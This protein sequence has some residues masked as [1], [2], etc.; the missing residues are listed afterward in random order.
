VFMLGSQQRKKQLGRTLIGLL[1]CLFLVNNSFTPICFLQ[2]HESLIGLTI[3]IVIGQI[4]LIAVWAAL[5]QKNLLFRLLWSVLL[6]IMIWLSLI[7]GWRL[8]TSLVDHEHSWIVLVLRADTTMAIF[9]G[10]I[11]AFGLASAQVP[12]W[13]MRWFFRWRIVKAETL[14]IVDAMQFSL[15]RLFFGTFLVAAMLLVARVILPPY[16]D[17][18]WVTRKDV[19]VCFSAMMLCNWGI[20]I[21]CIWGAFAPPRQPITVLIVL[22]VCCIVLTA[23]E[24]ALTAHTLIAVA[25][26]DLIIPRD[27]HYF[28]IMFLAANL[29]QGSI[30]FVCLILLRRL[31]YRLV[32]LPVDAAP[33]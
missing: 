27:L 18:Y 13:G 1:V 15:R 6:G 24:T 2:S 22:A 28:Y 4:S 14:N 32:R 5:T 11:V 8:S 16:E 9:F 29:A 7:L 12:L 25:G 30:L 33:H 21:P 31:G 23:V 10:S 19:W 3:G 17:W 20:T 26:V